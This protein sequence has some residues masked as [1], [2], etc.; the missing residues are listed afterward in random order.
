MPRQLA[1][2]SVT[3]AVTLLSRF[4]TT[5]SNSCS[6]TAAKSAVTDAAL[7]A[8][9]ETDLS[10]SPALSTGLA[11]RLAPDDRKHDEQQDEINGIRHVGHGEEVD[12]N[13]E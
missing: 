2:K 8:A 5:P 4:A 3:R 1:P 6:C 13:E 7:C 12:A 11:G 10:R 9:A